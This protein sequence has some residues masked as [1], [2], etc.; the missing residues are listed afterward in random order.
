MN[1]E[2]IFIDLS[3]KQF[4]ADAQFETTTSARQVG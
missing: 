2:Q 1:L 3:R 4:D